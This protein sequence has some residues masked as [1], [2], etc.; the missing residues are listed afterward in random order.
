MY[1]LSL[2]IQILHIHIHVAKGEITALI[3]VSFYQKKKKKKKNF[4]KKRIELQ[5]I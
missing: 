3:K 5:I 2:C 1:G 4:I